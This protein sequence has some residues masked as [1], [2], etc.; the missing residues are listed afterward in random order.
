MGLLVHVSQRCR[1]RTAV[2]AGGSAGD[3]PTP[4]GRRAALR[5]IF[6]P[7]A[8][9]ATPCR[10]GHG[11]VVPAHARSA[12]TTSSARNTAATGIRKMTTEAEVLDAADYSAKLAQLANIFVDPATKKPLPYAVVGER[13][14]KTSGCS[15]C[16]SVDGSLGQGPTWL[17]LY[18]RDVA[19]LRST[20]GLHAAGRRRRREMGRLPPRV[21]PRSRREGRAGLS[22]RHAVLC[23]PVQRH[24]L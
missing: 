1:Q 19:V 10:A 8:C 9:S 18:K 3:A 4:F 12:R 11:T 13:L 23:R 16:H 24:A 20:R 7:F 2:P 17:G 6:P 21:G 14:Y 15:Q 22:E 5:F